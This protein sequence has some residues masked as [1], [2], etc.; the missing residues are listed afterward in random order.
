[1]ATDDLAEELLRVVNFALDCVLENDYKEEFDAHG[2]LAALELRPGFFKEQVDV[3]FLESYFKKVLS[4]P[5]SQALFSL[6]ERRTPEEIERV[7]ELVS[8]ISLSKI[9]RNPAVDLADADWDGILRYLNGLFEIS[10]QIGKGSGEV[11]VKEREGFSSPFGSELESFLENWQPTYLDFF[12]ARRYVDE[13]RRLLP[14]IVK[15][16]GVLRILPVSRSILQR[17]RDYL[18]EASRSFVYGHFRAALLLC[19]SAIEYAVE[20]RLREMDYEQELR[21]ITQDWLKE[22]LGLARE[23]G[24]LDAILWAQAD[25]I[26]I[27]RNRA[28]H[29]GGDPPSA[30]ERQDAFVKTRGILQHVYE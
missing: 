25:E 15:R 20:T 18:V 6:K 5:R 9:A 7:F 12:V 2:D 24:V 1:M 3:T 14:N 28:A 19:W 30:Q 27:L 21:A 11:I 29:P 16:A 17:L 10:G 8:P 13:V 22:L 26:R 23:K 4:L